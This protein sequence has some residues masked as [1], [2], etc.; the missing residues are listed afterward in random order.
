M[1]L[2][3]FRMKSSQIG[4]N[5]QF[6]KIKFIRINLQL[7]FTTKEYEDFYANQVNQLQL[8]NNKLD[9]FKTDLNKIGVD[10][11][12]LRREKEYYESRYKYL[13]HKIEYLQRLKAESL[14]Q[15]PLL[16]LR[17]VDQ[18]K[19]NEEIVD[20]EQQQLVLQD[21]LA[22]L[23]QQNEQKYKEIDDMHY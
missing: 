17:G 21:Q 10:N 5:N 14:Q 23:Q 18:N 13:H 6:I 11:D 19:V 1:N 15:D 4:I 9:Y 3:T 22:K 16:E 7:N 20:L 2:I 12:R 8:S